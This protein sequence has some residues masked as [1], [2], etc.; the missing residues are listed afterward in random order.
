M[1]RETGT[2]RIMYSTVTVIHISNTRYVDAINSMPWKVNSC[3]EISNTRYVDAINSMPWKVNSCT[4]I[5]GPKQPWRMPVRSPP[6]GSPVIRRQTAEAQP[7]AYVLAL[8]ICFFAAA[9]GVA[10]SLTEITTPLRLKS[11][12]VL[13]SPANFLFATRDMPV[14]S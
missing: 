5:A 1:E 9:T 8:G 6:P 7:W 11:S 13:K 3:T 14:S 2:V 4:E 12:R 10:P